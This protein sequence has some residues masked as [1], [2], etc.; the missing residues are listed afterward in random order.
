MSTPP[1]TRFRA[2]SPFARLV[3]DVYVDGVR[4][5][6]VVAFDTAEGWADVLTGDDAGTPVYDVTRYYGAVTYTP[7]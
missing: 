3:G 4:L 1:G 5:S 7:R 6:N 2:S